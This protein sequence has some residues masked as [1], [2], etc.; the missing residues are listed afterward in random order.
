MMTIL[1]NTND[2]VVH[3]FVFIYS[4]SLRPATRSSKQFKGLGVW[5][6]G[7]KSRS[8][9]SPSHS[10]MLRNLACFWPG[11]VVFLAVSWSTMHNVEE[12]EQRQE[13]FRVTDLLTPSTPSNPHV[14]AGP[15]VIIPVMFSLWFPSVKLPS[16][17]IFSSPQSTAARP[18]KQGRSLSAHTMSNDHLPYSIFPTKHIFWGYKK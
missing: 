15:L 12:D 9:K 4:Y 1:Q 14:D 13:T 5:I 10:L 8:K 6:C 17:S 3:S 18:Q 2:N 7:V 16:L 11:P